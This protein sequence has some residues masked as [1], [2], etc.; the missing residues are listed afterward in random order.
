MSRAALQ[1]RVRRN[2]E[3]GSTGI[4]T[5]F[6]SRKPGGRNVSTKVANF[7]S[8]LRK[9]RPRIKTVAECDGGEN[10][11]LQIKP[12]ELRFESARRG[13]VSRR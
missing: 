2:A 9:T 7:G 6:G 3:A 10:G 8:Q 11:V 4:E 13:A 12:L 1:F 5:N